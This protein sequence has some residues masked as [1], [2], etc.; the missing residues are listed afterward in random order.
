MFNLGLLTRYLSAFGA[1]YF[2]TANRGP[3]PEANRAPE[4]ISSLSSEC[5]GY[6][7]T[8]RGSLRSL[9][10]LVSFH[11][12]ARWWRWRLGE[13][14]VTSSLLLVPFHTLRLR[15]EPQGSTGLRDG[16]AK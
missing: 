10:G 4:A 7:L 11:D 3:G 12:R 5:F 2:R 14:L 9:D 1:W 13:K 6:S 16:I 8:E 15:C